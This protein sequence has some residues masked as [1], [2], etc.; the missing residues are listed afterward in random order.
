MTNEERARKWLTDEPSPA[1]EDTVTSLVALLD[2][3]RA[4]ALREAFASEA[5][6]VFVSGTGPPLGPMASKAVVTGTPYL[7]ALFPLTCHCGV[8]LRDLAA[9][10][11][12]EC[13]ATLRP[14][15]S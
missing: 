2:E 13:P 10:A 12:H 3:V 4:E 1:D 6:L 14:R 5:P 11:V 15:E 9:C 8:E 7:V